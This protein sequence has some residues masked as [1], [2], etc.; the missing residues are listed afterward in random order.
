MA[1]G[2]L[3]GKEWSNF[4]DFSTSSCNNLDQFGSFETDKSSSFQVDTTEPENEEK[5]VSGY[6]EWNANFADAPEPAVNN[7]ED[8]FGSFGN[9]EDTPHDGFEDENLESLTRNLIS[10]HFSDSKCLTKVITECS[11]SLNKM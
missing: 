5:E 8:D 2:S 1:D 9:F 4:G 7:S 10:N 3:G 6:W 11:S